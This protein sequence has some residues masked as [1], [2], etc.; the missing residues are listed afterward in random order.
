[1]SNISGRLSTDEKRLELILRKCRDTFLMAHKFSRKEKKTRQ[2][3]Y[4]GSR[5]QV[6]GV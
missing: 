2:V 1:M 3:Q 5:L 4:G 6:P